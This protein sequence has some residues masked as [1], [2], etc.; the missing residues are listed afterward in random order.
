MLTVPPSSVAPVATKE[1]PYFSRHERFGPD[2][3]A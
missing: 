1:K 3:S 2:P